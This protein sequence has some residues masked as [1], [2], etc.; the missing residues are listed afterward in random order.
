ME[1]LKVKNRKEQN[2]VVLLEEAPSSKGLV[3]VM[4]G[5][6]GFKEQKHIVAFADSFKNKN[7]TVVRFDTTNTFGESEGNYENA[8]VTNYFEDLEDVIKWSKTQS[9]Y[10][11]PFYLIGHSLG[12]LCVILYAE[13][14][15]EEVK[16]LAPISTVVSGKLSIEVKGKENIEKWE[17]TGWREEKSE[18]IPGLVKRLKWSHMV[19]RLKYDVLPEVN[20]LTMPVLLI[21][22]DRD[23]GTP[24]KHQKLLYDKLPGKKE[25]HIIEHADHNF[26]GE[27]YEK[28]LESIKKIFSGWIDKTMAKTIK[29]EKLNVGKT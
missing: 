16:G 28:N 11:E 9:W 23:Y 14:F 7:F 19:D 4:H 24:L 8:T 10:K 26:R 27:E 29:S 21:V 15:P 2:I 3:F 5:L 18:S 20:K 13:K 25:L 12:A 1:K 6:S 17:K 22:G